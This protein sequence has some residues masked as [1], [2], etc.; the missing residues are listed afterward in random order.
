MDRIAF[1][2]GSIDVYWY[3]IILVTG[4][5]VALGLAF[6][7]TKRQHLNEDDLM[8][9]VLLMIPAAVV[10]ARLYYVLFR[11]SIFSADPLS[12][13][14][15]WHGGLAIHGGIIAGALMM[16]LYCHLKKQSFFRWA[17]LVVPCL[18]L[19]Q[20]IG[21]WGNFVNAEAYGPVIEEGSAWAWV[22]LQVL[23]EG[24]YHHPTFL[25]ESVW[26]LLVFAVLMILL[27]KRHKIG[28][29]FATY[30][31]MYS[32]GRFFIEMLRTDSLM[33]GD[34]RTAML[35]SALLLLAGILVLWKLE[36]QPKVDVTALPVELPEVEEAEEEAAEEP[37]DAEADETEAAAEEA[38]VSA[39]G[40]AA[41]EEPKPAAEEKQQ[42]A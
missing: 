26:N 34:L 5:I 39:E 10:G 32:T 23:V 14:K 29:V 35:V 2:I 22:P 13:F 9:M 27:H 19:G 38:E 1:S 16:L 31:I 40:E 7:E 17:D 28:S 42:E 20:A 36:N 3:G 15:V 4:M 30:L 33:I 11:W 41:E 37:A 21:R 18:A 12:I 25:Y 8:N 24:E 6:Y